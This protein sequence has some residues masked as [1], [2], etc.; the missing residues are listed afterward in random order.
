MSGGLI[1][2][3]LGGNTPIAPISGSYYWIPSCSAN[4]VKGVEQPKTDGL[5]FCETK[6]FAIWTTI[7]REG[8]VYIYEPEIA[9][10]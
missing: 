8:S 10:G 9:S 6:R 5:S 4:K 2:Y 3:G 7:G 1:L